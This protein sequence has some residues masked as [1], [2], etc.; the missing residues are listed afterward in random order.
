MYMYVYSRVCNFFYYKL[1]VCTFN[2]KEVMS[3]PLAEFQ[4]AQPDISKAR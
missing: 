3:M 4:K 2:N 1:F